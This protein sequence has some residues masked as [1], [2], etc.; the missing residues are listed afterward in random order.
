MAKKKKTMKKYSLSLV[1]MTCKLKPSSETLQ[2][3][4]NG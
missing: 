3:Y 1:T 2:T 4:E